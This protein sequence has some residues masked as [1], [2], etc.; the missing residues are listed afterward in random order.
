MPIIPAASAPPLPIAVD[1][2]KDLAAPL[3]PAIVA[4]RIMNLAPLGTPFSNN[5]SNT[6][7]RS[8]SSSNVGNLLPS[9]LIKPSGTSSPNISFNPLP[10][11]VSNTSSSNSL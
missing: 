9:V 6:F 8:S 3:V 10:T 11:P 2:N 5:F 7:V 1:G 4:R